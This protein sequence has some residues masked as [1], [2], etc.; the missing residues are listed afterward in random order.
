MVMLV[1]SDVWESFSAMLVPGD[2][3]RVT[4]SHTKVSCLS[5]GIHGK[6]VVISH[7]CKS[8]MVIRIIR[9]IYL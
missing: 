5:S 2:K 9:D 6:K 1:I 3:I 8:Y 7:V 4:V